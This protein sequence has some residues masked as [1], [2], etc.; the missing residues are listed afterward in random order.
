MMMSHN[1]R[2]YLLVLVSIIAGV[3]I[4][5]L[6]SLLIPADAEAQTTGVDLDLDQERHGQDGERFLEAEIAVT[7]DQLGQTCDANLDRRNNESIHAKDGHADHG[8]NIIV[9]SGANGTVFANVESV[10][11]DEATRSFVIDGTIRVYTQIGH[12]KVASMGYGLEFECSPDITTTTTTTS[13]T[14]TTAVPP[15][16]TLPPVTTTTEPAPINGVNTGGGALQ[17]LVSDEPSGGFSLSPGATWLA[18]AIFALVVGSLAMF[19]KA[20]SSKERQVRKDGG[21]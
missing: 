2:L 6:L 4:G 9:E 12:D 20:A 1:L 8:T 16:S 21:W 10:A 14:S 3:M 13:V 7:D 11:F 19:T 5:L 18:I 17:H 15:T